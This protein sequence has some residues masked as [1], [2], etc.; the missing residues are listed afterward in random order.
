MKNYQRTDRIV[1]VIG[2]SVL[3]IFVTFVTVCIAFALY[4]RANYKY[5][6]GIRPCDQP[7]TTWVSDDNQIVFTV[8]EDGKGVGTILHSGEEIEISAIFSV[9]VEIFVSPPGELSN[10][11]LKREGCCEVWYGYDFTENEFTVIVLETTY[12]EVDQEIHF[13]KI[14]K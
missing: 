2:I 6:Y 13:R 11:R 5:W 14:D 4:I 12:F 3:A 9:S 7:N 10:D 8:G 1:R